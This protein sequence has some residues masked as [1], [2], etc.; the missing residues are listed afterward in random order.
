MKETIQEG[1][2][3]WSHFPIHVTTDPLPWSLV[4]KLNVL[5]DFLFPWPNEG[6]ASSS[7]SGLKGKGKP[8][9]SQK[10]ELVNGLPEWAYGLKLCF[11]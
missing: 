7:W 8:V 1:F 11:I 10:V 6:S 9:L 4:V 3:L 2:N 5:E